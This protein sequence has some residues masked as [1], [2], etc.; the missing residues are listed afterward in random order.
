MPSRCMSLGSENLV[1]KPIAGHA[2][3]LFSSRL[4]IRRAANTSFVLVPRPTKTALGQKVQ[5]KAMSGSMAH[6]NHL[7][8]HRLRPF[9]A[10][11]PGSRLRKGPVVQTPSLMKIPASPAVFA[12]ITAC[13]GRWPA[14]G[15]GM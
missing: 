6:I 7:D 4:S 13:I 2:T 1:Q 11:W 8:N 15:Q 5:P 12:K 14:G 9:L 3:P 10:S